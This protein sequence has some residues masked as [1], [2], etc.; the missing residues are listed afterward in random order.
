MNNPIVQSTDQGLTWTAMD[1]NYHVDIHH[2]IYSPSNELWVGTDGGISKLTNT[3]WINKTKNM[4]VANLHFIS[5]A[6][7][8]SNYVLMGAYDVGSNMLNKIKAPEQRWKNFGLNDG[9]SCAID[10]KTSSRFYVTG[11]SG[12][13]FWRYENYGQTL[14]VQLTV[15]G[16]TDFFT[17]FKLSSLV[18]NT[19][20]FV[21]LKNIYRSRNKGETWQPI[22]TNIDVVDSVKFFYKLYTAPNDSNIM[23]VRDLGKHWKPERWLKTSNANANNP[24]AVIWSVFPTPKR[25]GDDMAI[26]SRNAN[27][28]WL[29]HNNWRGDTTVVKFDG[30]YWHDLTYNLKALQIWGLTSIVHDNLI[31]PSGRTYVG[32]Y[33]GVYYLDDGATQWT[34][35]DGLP[36]VKIDQ[37]EIDYNSGKLRAGTYGR[38]LWEAPIANAYCTEP[39]VITGDT[40]LAAEAISYCDLRV[41]PG[42]V[43]TI[44]GKL[45]MSQGKRIIIDKGG[46]LVLDAGTITG[47][48]HRTWQGI[49]V[50][51]NSSLSQI[52]ASNQGYLKTLNNALIEDAKTAVNTIKIEN[53]SPNY[54]NTGGIVNCNKTTFR[55]CGA[56]AVFHPYENH[57]PT[58]G[59]IINNVSAFGDCVFEVNSR[60]AGADSV[61]AFVSLTQVR[62]V[63]FAACKFTDD[64]TAGLTGKTIGIYAY[65]SAFKVSSTCNVVVPPNTPC[66]DINYSRFTGLEYGVKVLGAATTKTFDVD[67]ALFY[68]K[69]CGLYASS[70]DYARLTRNSF[71]VSA[72]D[73]CSNTTNCAYGG[74]YFDQCK[75]YTIE[76]N[77]FSKTGAQGNPS[78]KMVGLTINNS[79]PDNNQVYKNTFDNLD[80][81][82]LA[83]RQNK[84]P[85]D[86][87]RGLCLRC[88]N[89]NSCKYDIAVTK[90]LNGSLNQNG[91]AKTQ[92]SSTYPAGNLFTNT[93][94]FT[95]PTYC[96]YFNIQGASLLSAYQI[97]YYHHIQ[98]QQYRTIP[99]IRKNVSLVITNLS[100][101]LDTCASHLGGGVNPASKL[102]QS[103]NQ[104]TEKAEELNALI[105]GGATAETVSEVTYSCPDEALEIHDALLQKSPYLSDTVMKAAIEQENVLN[106]ALVRDILVANP[107]SAK[108]EELLNAVDQR[109]D[110]LTDYMIDEILEGAGIT[111][112]K[113]QL[114]ADV[115]MEHNNADGWYNCM[116]TG[117]LNDT[118]GVNVEA[119]TS[120]LDSRPRPAN[121]YYKAYK[122]LEAGDTIGGLQRLQEIPEQYLYNEAQN[123]DHY[124]IVEKYRMLG[125]LLSGNKP[126][127]LMDSLT[128]ANFIQNIAT[129]DQLGDTW[130]RNCLAASGKINF[131]EQYILPDLTKSVEVDIPVKK[132]KPT[133]DYLKVFPNPAREYIVIE[134]R[135]A[136]LSDSYIL[137]T[138]AMG[139]PVDKLVIKREA[140]QIT[141]ITKYLVSGIYN[142]SLSIDG[143]NKSS[144]RFTV[145]R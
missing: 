24:S 46:K 71:F 127:Q 145:V 22:T 54:T 53:G 101:G 141:Y 36:N 34:L 5:G 116:V 29:V 56:C 123:D 111:S 67:C 106:N 61:K 30:T 58:N 81:G 45:H 75:F 108:S 9:T 92:G 142:C 16:S 110:P 120:L 44:T 55:N 8:D 49:E 90:P 138:D 125:K 118:V 74:A 88:N 13:F 83:Q 122:D 51:G 63:Q 103:D 27:V 91:I 84:D 139:K 70:I 113:E 23:Y 144:I 73:T 50:W 93:D 52:P 134:Y 68:A 89:F 79:G 99:N 128:A 143:N 11:Q 78:Q 41:A 64:N 137:I 76:E 117:I 19:V 115:A 33:K 25:G 121:D 136:K 10:P 86:P 21:T 15:P 100:Y 72:T 57:H 39:V 28:L 42:A 59:G 35:M 130:L 77:T 47:Y 126:V 97:T 124:V 109:S 7:T 107:Q 131:T 140:D 95:Y 114:E 129:D 43:F 87:T 85:N 132:N 32:G 96:N 4:G 133:N 26:D 119:L 31:N 62:G 40:T 3:G 17:W 12:T 82:I 69:K 98:T 1:G 80:I 20:F 105:D 102:A 65:N 112:P 66:T 60:Y 104:A 2:L 94:F 48:L 37:L 38:G 6:V 14:P 135:A 18:D